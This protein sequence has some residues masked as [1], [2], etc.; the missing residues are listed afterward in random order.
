MQRW[1]IWRSVI[2]AVNGVSKRY[3]DNFFIKTSIKLGKN[4]SIKKSNQKELSETCIRAFYSICKKINIW[5]LRTLSPSLILKKIQLKSLFSSVW[6]VY[7]Q[8]NNKNLNETNIFTNQTSI[9]SWL[10]INT[11]INKYNKLWSDC[12]CKI[13]VSV[14]EYQNLL[15]LLLITL[16]LKK[17]LRLYV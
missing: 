3:L 12:L 7:H 1:M 11:Y 14:H 6:R 15:Y 17:L 8:V 10:M 9:I 16:C 13:K 5:R 2:F 4:I